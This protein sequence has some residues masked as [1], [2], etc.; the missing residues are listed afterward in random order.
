MAVVGVEIYED[1]TANMEPEF[2]MT[3]LHWEYAT[4]KMKIRAIKTLMKMRE[5]EY[6]KESLFD[7]LRVLVGIIPMLHEQVMKEVKC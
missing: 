7:K 4:W 3:M 2:V 1:G 5:A 6:P